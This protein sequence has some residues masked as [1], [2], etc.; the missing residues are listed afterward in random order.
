MLVG[1]M[2]EHLEAIYD[3]RCEAR[4]T[5]YLVDEETALRLGGTGRAAEELLVR[6]EGNGVEVALFLSKELIA[7]SKQYAGAPA[8][9]A[10]EDL[11]GFCQLTEG[12]SHF[13]YLAHVAAHDR[14]V[15]LLELEVQAEIDKFA[16]CALV[17]WRDDDP[18]GVAEL[19]AR[20]FDR[21]RYLETLSQEERWRYE[22]ANRLAR[23]Y[24][25]RL[26]VVVQSRR[27]EALLGDLRYCYRLGAEAKL[28]YLRATR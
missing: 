26:L 6:E 15:S 10:S 1:R 22:E 2:Q 20:L 19:H 16:A 4:A 17:Q 9:W 24:C 27:L 11:S 28:E 23:V 8:T 14:Q 18:H 5:D 12:V 3:I 13:V 7:R 21:V 25:R